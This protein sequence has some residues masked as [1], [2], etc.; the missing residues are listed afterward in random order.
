MKVKFRIYLPCIVSLFFLSCSKIE[1]VEIKFNHDVTSWSDDA[2]NIRQ[3][4]SQT[5]SIPEWNSGETNPKDSPAAYVGGRN[6]KVMA[7]FKGSHDGVYKIYTKGGPFHLT[8]ASVQILNGI[9]NPPW[10]K[11]ET[12]NIPAMVKVSD[13]TWSWKRKVWWLFTRQMDKSY[14][15]FY[16]VL[17]EPKAPWKQSSFPDSQNPWLEALDY[18]CA[19][20]D[21]EGTFEGVSNRIT[22]NIN[23]G[24]YAYDQISG[25]T[26]Y[27][28]YSPRRYNLT[29]FLD[30]L[31]GG[32]GNGSVVN[33][34]DCGMSVTTFSNLLGCQLWSSRMGWGFSL[35]EIIA[36]G[37]STFACPNWGC[38]FNYH[39]VA[40]TGDALASEPVFDACLKVDGDADP[41]NPPHTALLPKNIPF[42]DPSGIDYRE[43]LV[44]PSSITNCQAQPPEKVRPPVF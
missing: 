34:S 18:A 31:N 43:R 5:V 33:C 3:N 2:L 27:G 25:A 10:I 26:H 30:R 12:S 20:A 17:D 15:R 28:T 4:F 40:W 14:H 36:V 44:P 37:Y 19:W 35:N 23:N 32:W 22:D 13:V 11:F 6:V 8:T 41:V 7:K 24:P 42:D 21:G 29:A 1:V 38:G 39:E 16:I 9:S